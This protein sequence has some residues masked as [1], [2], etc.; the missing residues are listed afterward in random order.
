MIFATSRTSEISEFVLLAA[1][2][3]TKPAMSRD[4]MRLL[5]STKILQK[6]VF[7]SRFVSKPL[8]AKGGIQFLYRGIQSLYKVQK[9]VFA[10][11]NTL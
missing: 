10:A 7:T 3:E 11:N 6:P 5:E 2:Q 4:L 9:S 1:S 8:R